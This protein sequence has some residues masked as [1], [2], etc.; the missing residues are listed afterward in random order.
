MPQ[1]V[2]KL[3]VTGQS[4]RSEEAIAN[5]RRIC[6]QALHGRYRLSIV[7]VLEHPP[8]A[9]ADKVRAT[10]MLI[11][12]RPVPVRRVVGELS[13]AAAVLRELGVAPEAGTQPPRE[14]DR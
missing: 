2:L 12:E 3:Y 13:D 4:P 9:E 1:F 14:R 10:P 8:L 11:K 7:D 6:E 5:V